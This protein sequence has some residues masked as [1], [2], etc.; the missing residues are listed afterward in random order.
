MEHGSSKNKNVGAQQAAW[1]KTGGDIK[2]QRRILHIRIGDLGGSVGV[3][4]AG[5]TS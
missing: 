2:V 5:M 1:L 4:T 3:V